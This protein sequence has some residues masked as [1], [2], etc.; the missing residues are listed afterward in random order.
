MARALPGIAAED[1]EALLEALSAWAA[2]QL[3]GPCDQVLEAAL[4]G[5]GSPRHRILP[6]W[7]S[8]SPDRFT[9]V[10]CVPALDG[11]TWNHPVLVGDRL[12]LRNDRE[13]AAFRL[14]AAGG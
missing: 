14:A 2:A 13:M 1:P 12:L 11:K 9:E 4:I 6:P 7:V 3:R 5:T 8:A 10:A